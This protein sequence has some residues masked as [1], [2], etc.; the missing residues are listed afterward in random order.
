MPEKK[1][2]TLSEVNRENNESFLDG[3]AESYDVVGDSLRGMMAGIDTVMSIYMRED[4]NRY[5]DRVKE[6]HL[7]YTT[8]QAFAEV[9][10][11]KYLDKMNEL[12]Q[13]F[14]LDN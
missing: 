14:N 2:H 13:V 6:L 4:L 10:D 8:L 7:M 5:E 9:Y 12:K 11:S 3:F 1:T